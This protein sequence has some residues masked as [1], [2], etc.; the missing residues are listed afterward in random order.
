MLV[1]Y[2]IA[3]SLELKNL[4]DIEDRRR[5][6]E[7]YNDTLSLIANQS[8]VSGGADSGKQGSI[9]F[10]MNERGEEG[11]SGAFV[12]LSLFSPSQRSSPVGSPRLLG[13]PMLPPSSGG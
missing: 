10:R 4:Q 12:E 7:E 9:S 13:W 5:I 3:D 1:Y 11:G 2:P 8:P 6:I